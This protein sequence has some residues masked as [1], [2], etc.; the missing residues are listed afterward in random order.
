MC[1]KNGAKVFYV[2]FRTIEV[3]PVQIFSKQN[4]IYRSLDVFNQFPNPNEVV[5]SMKKNLVNDIYSVKIMKVDI[6]Y[7]KLF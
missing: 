6:P 2:L 7:S 5:Q 1:C 3:K 4:H